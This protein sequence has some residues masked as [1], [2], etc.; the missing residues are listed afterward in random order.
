MTTHQGFKQA[1]MIRYDRWILNKNLKSIPYQRKAVEWALE[2]ELRNETGIAG[3]IIADEMGMGK[4]FMMLGTIMA[5]PNSGVTLLVVPPALLD[6]WQS[7]IKQHMS[8]EPGFLIVYHGAK[9]KLIDLSQEVFDILGTRIVLTTYGMMANRKPRRN[10]RSYK[11]PIWSVQWYRT[12]YD[13]A[14]HMRNRKS[15]NWIGAKVTKCKIR[16]LLTGTP[17]QNYASDA[18]ALRSL[19]NPTRTLVDMCL[20]RDKK[21]VGLKLPPINT[22]K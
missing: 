1:R 14:H 20:H 10:E 21:S 3:G 17:I 4:T 13:E 15:N 7:I 5:N 18:Y 8:N 9:A 22:K 12:I 6:Q 11:S 2:R 19:I 16:W